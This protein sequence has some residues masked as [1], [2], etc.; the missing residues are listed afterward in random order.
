MPKNVKLGIVGLGSRGRSLLK[1]ATTAIE[2]VEA[3]ALC[4]KSPEL[5]SSL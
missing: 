1:I 3:V 4:E 5:L 2:G